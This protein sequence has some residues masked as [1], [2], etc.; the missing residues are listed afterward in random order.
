MYNGHMFDLCMNEIKISVRNLVEFLLREGDIDSRHTHSSD[1]AMQEGSRV[2]R[3]IQKSMGSD[4]HAEVPLS[5]AYIPEKND[6]TIILDGRADG[7]IDG[8]IVTIDEIKG[9]YRHLE[10]MDEPEAVHLAQAKCYAYMYS[11][12]NELSDINVRI[13]YCNLENESLRYFN[14]SYSYDEISRWFNDLMSEYE[15]WARLEIEWKQLRN[16]SIKEACFPFKYREGQKELITH[17]YHTIAHNRKLFLEAPTGVGK[18]ISTIFPS[19]KAIGEGKADRIFYLTAKG[20]TRTVAENTF[21]LMRENALHFKSVVITAKDKICFLEKRDCN[22][23][24]CEFAKGH[25][26][27][28][29]ECL[30]AILTECEVYSREVIERY[31]KE[32]RV[33]P[34]ELCLDISLFADAVICDYNYVFDPHVY[35]RRFFAAGKSSDSIFLIDE[36]HNLIDRGRNMYSAVLIKEDFLELK[37][38]VKTYDEKM[39]K[40]LERCNH[41]MLTFKRTCTDFCIPEDISQLVRCIERLYD[42]MEDYLEN[43]DSSPVRDEVLDFFFEISHFLMIYELSDE[44]YIT[45]CFLDDN[46]CFGIK[47]YCVDPSTNLAEC[48]KRSISSILFSATLL[49]IQYHKQLLGGT[50][51]D[52]EVYANSTFDRKKRGLYIADGVTSKYSERSNSMYKSIADYIYK[53]V[54]VRNGNYMVF[55]PSYIFMKRVLEEFEE[56]IPLL[57]SSYKIVVQNEHMSESEREEFLSDFEIS[58]TTLIGFCILGGIF[59]EGIDLKNDCLIGSIIVGTGLPMVCNENELI[60]RYFDSRGDDGYSY[61]YVYPGFNKVLQAAGR[62]IRTHDDVGIVALL[63]YRFKYTS[64]KMLYPREWNDISVVNSSGIQDVLYDFWSQNKD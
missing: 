7:I 23:D 12:E 39:A 17:V 41:E 36:A 48:M 56:I 63:D 53:I 51:E 10:K 4:Y 6:F 62:V 28:I 32:Y 37:K 33:C 14:F 43:H 1:N 13:T 46:G 47:L 58:G 11:T 49:P 2:H 3:K 35:L 25:F 22:P 52:Y 50:D 59:S 9:T 42:S 29:N 20:I 19:V 38:S 40:R 64:Y 61:A 45:Y 31:A 24:S 57:K 55:F 54:S 8:D 34:F 18:T 5:F 26:D 15:R 60:K 44:K 27:R 21:S 16:S 30:Y